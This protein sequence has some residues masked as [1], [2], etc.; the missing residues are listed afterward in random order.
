MFGT[1]KQKPYSA[2]KNRALEVLSG[3]SRAYSALAAELHTYSCL[4][5]QS[6]NGAREQTV[7]SSA[8]TTTK[9]D[10]T[11]PGGDRSA[12]DTITPH[13]KMEGVSTYDWAPHPGPSS[14]SGRR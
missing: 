2:G 8:T 10:G 4:D 5:G 7:A 6:E 3:W 14:R 12:I 11:A 9:G 1:D 13:T